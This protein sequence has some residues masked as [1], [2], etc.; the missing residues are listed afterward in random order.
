METRADPKLVQQLRSRLAEAGGPTRA[1]QRDGLLWTGESRVEYEERVM[2]DES[3]W[4]SVSMGN[5]RSILP[6]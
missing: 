3:A 4:L 6:R 2:S 5:A 1:K